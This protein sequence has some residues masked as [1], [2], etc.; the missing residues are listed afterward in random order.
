MKRLTKEEARKFYLSGEVFYIDNGF[1]RTHK[2]TIRKDWYDE[3]IKEYGKPQLIKNTLDYK[4]MEV[5][6]I[7]K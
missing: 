7:K 1:I 5:K 6:Y 3:F 2:G 4:L